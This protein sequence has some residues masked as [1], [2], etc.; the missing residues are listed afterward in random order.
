MDHRLESP[1]KTD[2][3]Y[4]YI[5]FFLMVFYFNIIIANKHTLYGFNPLELIAIWFSSDHS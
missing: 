5:F 1:V 4:I 2:T 3:F